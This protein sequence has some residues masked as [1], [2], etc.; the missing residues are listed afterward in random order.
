MNGNILHTIPKGPL[1][2]I[3]EILLLLC[4]VLFSTLIVLNP[5]SQDMEELLQVP[6]RKLK[7]YPEIKESRGFHKPDEIDNIG[8][9]ANLLCESNK[10][11]PTTKCCH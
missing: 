3:A 7:T 6:R 4:N 5:F 9:I 8:N 2:I 11:I 1:R 10:K